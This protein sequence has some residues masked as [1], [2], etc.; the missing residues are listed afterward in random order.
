MSLF[1]GVSCVL[2]NNTPAYRLSNYFRENNSSFHEKKRKGII[3]AFE[4][5]HS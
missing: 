1:E 3:E 5:K 2:H 4:I